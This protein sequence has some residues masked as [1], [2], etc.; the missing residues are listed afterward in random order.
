MDT[1][2]NAAASPYL[3]EVPLYYGPGGFD[4]THVVNINWVYDPPKVSQ[5][6]SSGFTRWVF[7]LTGS[8]T[9]T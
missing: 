6:W 1:S 3:R 8:F 4:R 9:D 2:D 5:Y 7:E